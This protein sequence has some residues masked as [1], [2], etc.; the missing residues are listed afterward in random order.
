[1]PTLDGT[2]RAV[3]LAPG[4][5]ITAPGLRGEAQLTDVGPAAPTR[6][7]QVDAS[8][9]AWDQALA[10]S[11]V[12]RTRVITLD[13]AEA[14]LPGRSSVRAPSGE[15]GLVVEIPDLGESVGQ[16]IVSIDEGGVVTWNFPVDAAGRQAPG[17]RGAGDLLRYV[18][19]N[20][21]PPPE[22]Q[23]AERGL[24]GMVGQKILEVLVFPLTDPILGEITQAFAGRWETA[25][26][27]VRVR[28]FPAGGHRSGDA[29]PITG[30]EWRSLGAGPSLWFV[31]GTFSTSQAGFGGLPDATL[32]ELHDRY[33]GRVAAFD[34]H[35]LSVSPLDNVDALAELVPDGV[36]ITADI[37]A[38][39]RGGLVGRALSG[40]GGARSPV[41]VRRA[42]YV[43]TPNHGTPLASPEHMVSFVDRVSTML[44]LVPDPT[45]VSDVLEAVLV[46]V[47]MVARV[48][49]TALPGLASMDPKG[50][51][52]GDFNR[53]VD[54]GVVHHA[55]AADYEPGGAVRRLVR[56][57]VKD[58]LMDRVFQDSANDLVVPTS[59]VYEGSADVA[60]PIPEDRRLVF[61]PTDA[62]F[63]GGFFS[64]PATSEALL[65]WLPG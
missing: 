59:G 45:A 15:D 57:K 25:N 16:V 26:R 24:L 42:V 55:I 3:E 34:H 2:E 50:D 13:V 17:T 53:G 7:S 37:V 39:S 6:A 12:T 22:E 43:G 44:N 31:H 28:G 9:P 48:G 58:G 60:F 19:R 63:H 65:R 49:L 5:R 33:G 56:H 64:Q 38:H 52:L 47:K 1:M 8:R 4:V 35:S 11:G 36:S 32:R 10:S 14:P 46:V 40:E 27:P 18:I 30:E 54:T 20:T 29:A 41:S 21:T 61:G 51:F 62:V 23:G